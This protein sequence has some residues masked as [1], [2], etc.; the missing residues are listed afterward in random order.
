MTERNIKMKKKIFAASVCAAMVLTFTGCGNGSVPISFD[1]TPSST[2]P[3]TP[4]SVA[5]FNN[6]S[7]PA[8]SKPGQ[9]SSVPEQS[10]TPKPVTPPTPAAPVD[11][12]NVPVAKDEDFDYDIVGDLNN[13]AAVLKSYVGSSEYVKMPSELGG[14]K[15]IQ[16]NNSVMWG[17][18]VKAIMLA[19]G[20]VLTAQYY[21]TPRGVW[22]DNNGIGEGPNVTEIVF[23]DK[24]TVIGAE[25][26]T[27]LERV[28][29]PKY[30]QEIKPNGFKDSKITELV[31]PDYI[32]YIDKYAF[33]GCAD[34]S[35][36]TF[37]SSIEAIDGEA[38]RDCTNLTEIN[39]PKTF[40]SGKCTI[41]GYAFSGCTNLKSVEL[42][43]GVN[44]SGSIIKN[45]SFMG[46]DRTL[47]AGNSLFSNCTSLKKVTFAEGLDYIPDFFFYGCTSLTEVNLPDGL[48]EIGNNAFQ[49]C[50]SL[51]EV[52]LPNG[53]QKIGVGAFGNCTSLKNLTIPN[54]TTLI[55]YNLMKGCS[56]FTI[57]YLGQTFNPKNYVKIC[58]GE[59][60]EF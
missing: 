45:N 52:N 42:P 59:D 54:T 27:N 17:T 7:A 21:N 13:S 51:S 44:F 34:L 6:S 28:T 15:I 40:S 26:M 9:S 33:Q 55:G 24:M 12:D 3:S 18:R 2:E 57:S 58:N 1:N 48:I 39:F 53:L 5:A 22:L 43:S 56:D 38:F 46:I 60:F 49:D 37:P 35:S 50:S 10:S 4:S 32:K 14:E 29:L 19:D 8:N 41:V 36:V 25:G 16:V 23:P 20:C 30:L 31:L 11:W 47:Y